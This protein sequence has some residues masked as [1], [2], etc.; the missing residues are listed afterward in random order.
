LWIG[1]LLW[2]S[3]SIF[4]NDI[5]TSNTVN[6]KR[7]YY[8]INEI[9]IT[10]P[11]DA[12]YVGLVRC[13]NIIVQG[14]NL[15]HNGQG[16]LLIETNNSI[17]TGNYIAENN[18]GVVLFGTVAPCTNNTISQNLITQNTENINTYL[19]NSFNTIG[20]NTADIPIN[21]PKPTLSSTPNS[22]TTPTTE[23]FPTTLVIAFAV[24]V[25][26]VGLGFLVYF[27]KCKHKT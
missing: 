26:V 10:V 3:G 21:T 27:K 5:D 9:D 19:E 16:V 7:V 8:W 14:L 6:G 25:A 17:V 2:N 12:G 18:Y 15:T 22:S 1:S 11:S 24:V 20:D 13:S 4:I 23:P